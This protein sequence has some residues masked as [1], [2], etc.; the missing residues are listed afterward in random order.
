M[1]KRRIVFRKNAVA[2]LSLAAA[3][4]APAV[5]AKEPLRKATA[6]EVS[7]AGKR[8]PG[9][10]AGSPE[11]PEERPH[12]TL[13][14]TLYWSQPEG[15]VLLAPAL[16]RLADEG[17]GYCRLVTLSPDGHDFLVDLPPEP[18]SPECRGYRDLRYLDINGDGVLDLAAGAT[19]KANS[20][21]GYVEIAVVYL[22]QRD[23]PGAYCYS[24][25]AS[26]QLA[27]AD[28]VSSDKVGK[29]LERHR[30][31]LGLETFSCADGK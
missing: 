18:D 5:H 12:I 29:A 6:A 30:K 27:P 11:F 25:Q 17:N 13:P 16:V 10:F 9:V 21:E 1:K 7:D 23:R 28:M 14:G 26:R 22:S 8:I 31:R 20:F 3:L 15:G 2:M 24:E 19:V 4:S